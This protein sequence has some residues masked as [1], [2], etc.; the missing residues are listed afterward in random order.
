MICFGHLATKWPALM[1]KWE[2]VEKQLPRYKTQN[3]KRQLAYR[4]KMLTIVVMLLSLG[5][6]FRERGGR[7]DQESYQSHLS[8][9]KSLEISIALSI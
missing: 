2:N 4:I 5:K 9:K 6:C 8:I 7:N 3:E 1:L